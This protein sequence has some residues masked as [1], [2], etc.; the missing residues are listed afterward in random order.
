MARIADQE[1]N[2]EK[3]VLLAPHGLTLDSAGNIYVGEVAWALAKV[4]RK[5][6]VVRKF[7]RV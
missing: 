1:P 3:A 7:K 2:K 5:G 6:R 4:D